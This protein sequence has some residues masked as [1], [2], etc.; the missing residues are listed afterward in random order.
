MNVK[1]NSAIVDFFDSLW[2]ENNDR[3]YIISLIEKETWL[4]KLEILNDFN[5]FSADKWSATFSKNK[6]SFELHIPNNH[7][8]IDLKNIIIKV[9]K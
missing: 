9:N 2:I 8:L 5:Y 6:F 3:E 1:N 7:S 4:T